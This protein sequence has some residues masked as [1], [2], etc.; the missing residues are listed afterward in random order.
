VKEKV[1]SEVWVNLGL[2]GLKMIRLWENDNQGLRE[3]KHMV[4]LKE[5]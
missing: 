4:E 3:S 2:D 5:E 1:D